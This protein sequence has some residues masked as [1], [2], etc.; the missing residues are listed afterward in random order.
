MSAKNQLEASLTIPNLITLVRIL[1]TPL[2]IALLLQGNYRKAFLVF[3]LAVVTDVADGL[4]ARMW[5]QKSP[6]GTFLDPLADKLLLSSAYLTLGV[7]RLVP[8]WLV[9]VVFS[10]DLVLALGVLLLKIFD[11]PVIIKPSLA[12]KITAALQMATVLLALLGTF[13]AVPRPML[14]AF[15]WAAGLLT[16]G[17]G[18]HYV[19]LGLKL[20]NQKQTPQGPGDPLG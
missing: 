17:S 7:F 6:L 1:L 4:T 11:Y 10:R 8:P 16:A 19:Y 20:A 3:I 9:V 15:F 13:T 14:Q 2:F 12:G 5:Q 18:I